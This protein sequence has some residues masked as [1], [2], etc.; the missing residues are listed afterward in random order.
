[1]SS[2]KPTPTSDELDAELEHSFRVPPEKQD[3]ALHIQRAFSTGEHGPAF[4]FGKWVGG[5]YYVRRKDGE[6]EGHGH[7]RW[8]KVACVA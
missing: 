5:C 1:M 2:P 3:E 4:P 6:A 8:H 7:I